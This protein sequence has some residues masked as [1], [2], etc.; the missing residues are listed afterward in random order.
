MPAPTRV[1]ATA[2]AHNTSTT[3][4][5][6]TVSANSGD[7][8][9]VRAGNENASQTFGLPTAT[10]LTFTA[11][12]SVGT[13]STTGRSA[14]W[15]A[16]AGSTGSFTIS[17]TETGAGSNWWGFVASVWRNHGG[18]GN[19][20]SLASGTGAPSVS[21]TTSGANSGIDFLTTD[22]NAVDGTSRTY[23]SVNGAATEDNYFR[24]SV[25][26]A[27]YEAYHADAGAAG[28]KAV[29]ETAPT[30]QAYSGV[31][32]EILAGAGG[33]TTVKKLAALGVG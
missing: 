15:S 24:D 13:S 32:I 4:Q 1:S 12:P 7:L 8:I 26:Y 20:G 9:I 5:S 14:L 2:S 6:V 22:F 33:G 27:I 3:P 16:T 11:G 28:A 17:V 31:A 29:G 10:G 30:G 21:I 25:H 18:V 19:T 23:R